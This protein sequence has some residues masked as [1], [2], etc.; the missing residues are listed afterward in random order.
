MV[1]SVNCHWLTVFEGPDGAG[2]T[3]AARKY[4]ERM[5]A[6]YVHFG[7][8]TRAGQDLA[9]FYV[10][11][12]LPA[13][14]GYQHVVMDRSWLS[15]PIYSEVYRGVESRI[16]R[17]TQAILERLA[18][19]CSAVVVRCDP[20][21]DTV[22]QN[23]ESRKKDELLDHTWQL[24]QIYSRYTALDTA[25][26]VVKYDYRADKDGSALNDERIYDLRSP[27]HLVKYHTAGV[28]NSKIII[29]GNKLSDYG[30]RDTLYRWPFGSLSA[31][32][33]DHWLS[34]KLLEAGISEDRLCWINSSGDERV[35][36]NFIDSD[37]TYDR[38]TFVI[39]GREADDN[40]SRLLTDLVSPEK[41]VFPHPEDWVQ[42][43]T[44]EPYPL[45]QFLKEKIHGH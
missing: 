10:E 31:L 29:V 32:S 28:W 35:L 42:S 22:K 30:P 1:Q 12:M 41:I 21:F 5:S 39:L 40:F 16:S 44:K 2:K 18:F 36:Q 17:P 8:F 43:Q 7:P 19:K 26:P 4:A 6:K 15:E 13:L 9:R 11:G 20:G 24:S 27:S 25:L 38:R 33:Y 14:H 34:A 23:F 3:T 45:I 37:N